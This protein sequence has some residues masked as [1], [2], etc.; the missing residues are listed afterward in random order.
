MNTYIKYCPNVFVAKCA[1]KH[2][3]G[4]VIDVVTKYGKDNRCIVFN[5]VKQDA[6]FY[7]YSIV[8]E[9]GFNYHDFVNRKIERI[10]NTQSN[11]ERKANEYYKKSQSD[12]DFLSLAEPIK[13]GHHSENRHRKILEKA[14]NN[15]FK[16]VENKDKAELLNYKIDY[17][18]KR[19]N[20]INLSMPECIDYYAFEVEQKTKKHADLKSGVVKPSHS[21][22]LTYAK[23]DLNEAVKKLNIAKILWE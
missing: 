1:E 23:K 6:E 3:K 8:R 21:Y 19:K 16:Y 15:M 18:E 7:Y 4:E 22:S 12:N 17:W 20:D 14:N 9:D 10:N 11:I 2:E 5:L 13:V